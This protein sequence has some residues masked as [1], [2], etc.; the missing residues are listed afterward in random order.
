MRIYSLQVGISPDAKYGAQNEALSSS[1]APPLPNKPS[2]AVLPFDNMS[3]DPEQQY[4]SDGITEDIITA[5]SRFRQLFVIARNSSF[6]FRG[7]QVNAGEIGRQL[8]VQYLVEGSVR[9]A[10]GRIRI[11]A[12]LID[13]ISGMHVWADRYDREL[14]DLF[15]VQDEVAN[16]IAS[17]LAGQVETAAMGHVKRKPT[18]SLSAYDLYLR[19]KEHHQKSTDDD[20]RQAKELLK[21]AIDL[22][23]NF[24]LPYSGLAFIH[25]EDWWDTGASEALNNAIAFAKQSIVLDSSDVNGHH[26]LGYCYLVLR[27]F[28]RAEAYFQRGFDLNNNDGDGAAMFSDFYSHIGKPEEALL[29]ADRAIRLSPYHPNWYEVFRAD[30]RYTLSGG[31]E[32]AM[33]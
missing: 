23:P 8:G 25:F 28:D 21:R 5:L 15:I 29:W 1:T 14:D 20:L 22:D 31:T 10:G 32:D 33:R 4:F 9:K 27:Q 11:T 19:A 18:H 26:V 6:V 7:K 3:G 17:T 30:G 24:S 12:Q 2:I 13:S 16:T